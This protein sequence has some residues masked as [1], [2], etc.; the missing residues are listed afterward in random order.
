MQQHL[1]QKQ[2]HGDHS[3]DAA[4][5]YNLLFFGMAVQITNKQPA[6]QSSAPE[7]GFVSSGTVGSGIVN[8]GTASVIWKRIGF[9]KELESQLIPSPPSVARKVSVLALPSSTIN[10]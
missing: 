5:A 3:A 2:N 1:K 8:G 9:P 4:S 7:S 6:A 10:A